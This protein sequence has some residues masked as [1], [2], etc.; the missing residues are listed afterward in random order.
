MPV[1]NRHLPQQPTE[2]NWALAQPKPSGAT[3]DWWTTNTYDGSGSGDNATFGTPPSMDMIAGATTQRPGAQVGGGTLANM[4]SASAQYGSGSAIA[5]WTGQ[6]QAPTAEQAIGSPGMEYALG[7]AQQALERSAA[8]K[9]TLLTGGTLRDLSENQIGMAL[10]GYG[11]VYNRA[12]SEYDLSKST[13]Y[14]QQDRPFSKYTTLAELGRP[15]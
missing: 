8:A 13:F 1:I 5:P 15:T 7:R 9:G 4:G 14:E 12:R 3:G 10:Q 11:D 6:F 2:P